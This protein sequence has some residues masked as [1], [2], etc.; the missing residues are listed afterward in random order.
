MYYFFL[1]AL[2][3]VLMLSEVERRFADGVMSVCVCCVCVFFFFFRLLLFDV[4]VFV[5]VIAGV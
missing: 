3:G 4:C 5:V 1:L 2:C